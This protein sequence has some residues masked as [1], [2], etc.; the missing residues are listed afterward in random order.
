MTFWNEKKSP[1]IPFCEG[2]WVDI[3]EQDVCQSERRPFLLDHVTSS[4]PDFTLRTEGTVAIKDYI[5]LH[6]GKRRGRVARF[7][8][9]SAVSEKPEE[10]PHA[11]FC[12]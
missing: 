9:S 2:N 11:R 5:L 6:C 8:F 10:D 4:E 1:F 12:P 7:L 3:V